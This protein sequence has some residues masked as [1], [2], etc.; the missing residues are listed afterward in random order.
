M[1]DNGAA[2]AY[3]TRLVLDVEGNPLVTTDARLNTAMEHTFGM[4]G[5]TLR[6]KSCDAGE[7]WMLSDVNGAVL[8]SWDERLHT[9]R[10]TYD[11]ARRAT[12]HYVQQG[13]ED[14]QLV[15]RT[16]YGEAH[17]DAAALN[18]R[19]KPYQVYD[20][21]GVVTSGA[22][23]FKGNLLGG[24]RRLTADYHA[25]PDWSPLAGLTD[26]AAIATAAEAL[27][28]AEA[29]TSATAYDALN[30][31]T[32]MT[33]PDASEM[34]PTYNEAGLLEKVEARVRGAATWTTFVDDIDYD[35]RGQR[36]KIVYGNGTQ[37]TYTYDPETFRLVRLKTVRDSDD[38]VLQ[39]LTY[40]YDPVGNIT[41]IKDTAQQT[42]FFDNDVVSPSAQ[43]V[44]DALYRLIEATGREHA[45][46]V[47]DMQRDQSDVPLMNLPHA[48]DT[49]ALRNYTEKYVYDAVGNLLKMSHET[50]AVDWTRRYEIAATS[51]RLL[52]TSL[53]GDGP[54][55]THFSATYAYDEHG[56]MTSMPHLPA[57]GW[58]HNDQIQ[59]VDLGGGGTAYYTYDA[60]GQ[61]VRKVGAQRAGRGADLSRRV[62]GVPEAGFAK[63]PPAGTRD[64][65]WDE[66]GAA[67]STGGDEDG[68]CGRRR[69][70][71][72]GVTDEVSA[73]QSPGVGFARDG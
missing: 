18:L 16:V 62:G 54:T 49:A 4:G 26:I 30:R 53:P 33:A 15:R 29:F 34:R 12:H 2:G 57:I 63:E 3:P 44:Y 71:H 66:W 39:N 13:V 60:A 20:G 68:G 51:N 73:R 65:P 58:D 69:G 35:A 67:D 7:R 24:S 52:S 32:S 55:A 5:R 21:A 41:E 59:E 27:L 64:T 9:K 25:V 45:G 1:E 46:G 17:P 43:Y 56:S 48:N 40:T 14:E 50:G 11:A 8:R 72:A 36:E 6:Q 22:Y 10:A 61:R 37:T 31:P 47:A 23:D 70:V 19:G 38:A 28:E 42:V